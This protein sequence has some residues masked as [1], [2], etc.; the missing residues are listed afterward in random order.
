MQQI[1]KKKNSLSNKDKLTII[2]L[3]NSGEK[4]S[5]LAE[6]FNVSQGHFKS[7]TTLGRKLKKVQCILKQKD[8]NLR[9]IKG[10]IK[11]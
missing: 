10:R 2:N 4:R 7:Q 9:N 8:L 6:Q 11:L 3:K 1:Y 5:R